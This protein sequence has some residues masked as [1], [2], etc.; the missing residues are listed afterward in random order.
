VQNYTKGSD[1]SLNLANKTEPLEQSGLVIVKACVKGLELEGADKSV[2]VVH[3][4]DS[5]VALNQKFVLVD[6]NR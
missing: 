1:G 4:L 6:P 3:Q 5:S 2:P